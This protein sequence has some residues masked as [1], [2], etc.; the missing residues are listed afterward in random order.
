MSWERVWR[1][2]AVATIWVMTVLL[3]QFRARKVLRGRQAECQQPGGEEGRLGRLFLR[4][5]VWVIQWVL[6]MGFTALLTYLY[7]FFSESK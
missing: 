5:V 3:F 4:S 6:L 1:K 2:I 7:F